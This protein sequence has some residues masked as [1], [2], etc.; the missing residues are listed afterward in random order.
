MLK[1]LTKEDKFIQ[2]GLKE[3]DE[4]IKSEDEI[5]EQAEY[6]TSLLN[7]NPVVRVEYAGSTYT[8]SAKQTKKPEKI[9]THQ[10][11][12]SLGIEPTY[13]ITHTDVIVLV[14]INENRRRQAYLSNKAYIAPAT[15]T[16]FYND[17]FTYQENLIAV[18]E[19]FL[20]HVIGEIKIEAEDDGIAKI[21]R[22]K[23][24]LK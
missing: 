5:K 23:D 2:E 20:R 21:A 16:G 19:A 3:I 24:F 4:E 22:E 11:N 12:K 17:E 9:M 1:N 15:Y 14:A 13:K 7:Q 18:V 6:I 8:L 10:G